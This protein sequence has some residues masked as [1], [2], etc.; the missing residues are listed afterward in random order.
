M[1]T[2]GI[3]ACMNPIEASHSLTES[4]DILIGLMKLILVVEMKKD[5]SN[6]SSYSFAQLR[7]MQLC[8]LNCL[9]ILKLERPKMFEYLI[10]WQMPSIE[11]NTQSQVSNVS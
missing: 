5:I 11:I 1:A 3:Y 6:P 10:K 4:I 8:E 2:I 7:F 9:N